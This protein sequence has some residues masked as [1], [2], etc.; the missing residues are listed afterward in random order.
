MPWTSKT[1]ND[2]EIRREKVR[3]LLQSENRPILINQ[4]AAPRH[5]TLVAAENLAV[6]SHLPGSG[7]AVKPGEQR[8]RMI[9]TLRQNDVPE[10]NTYLD[11][12]DTAMVVALAPI[13]VGAKKGDRFDVMVRLANQSEATDLAEGWLRQTQLVEMGN[14]GGRLRESFDLAVAEGSIVT[15]EQYSGSSDPGAKLQAKVVGGAVF[16]KDR[17]LGLGL[18]QEYAEAITMAAVVPVINKRFTYFDGSKQR[19]VAT[20]QSEDFIDLK[21]PPIYRLD[22]YHY[23]QVVMGLGFNE[24]SDGKRDR[25]EQL[26]RQI[27]LPGKVRE[28]CWQ[29][30]AEGSGAAEVLKN[31]LT[32]PDPEV[33][34]YCAHSLAYLSD[35]SAINTL[36][37]LAVS[38]S[39]FRQMCLNGL[40]ILEN[41]QAEEQL[42][43]LLHVAE[44]E[45]RYGAVRALR[46]RNEREPLVAGSELGIG[47]LLEIPSSGPALVA[48]SLDRQ[49]EIVF[50]GPVPQLNFSSTHNVSPNLLLRRSG[51]NGIIVTRLRPDQ[52]DISVRCSD[53]LPS[54]LRAMVQVRSGYGD[55][56]SLVRQCQEH[57]L[58]DVPVAMNPVPSSGRTYDRQ[59]QSSPEVSAVDELEMA[60]QGEATKGWYN[61]WSWWN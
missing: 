29:L 48:V 56:V 54:V 57:R 10:P 58:M 55:W 33:R 8:D 4:L 14:L 7:G 43:S 51:Q 31:G 39:A 61:P 44:P 35:P 28:A 46:D 15:N 1:S 21:I 3:K 23:V 60:S 53:D 12:K 17:D 34:F 47:S 41:H 9:E 13:G 16:K 42:K 50:F 18:M 11:G 59:T 37:E 45:V 19:G 36:A 25:L 32:D 30:E 2:I 52:E 20:P 38:Q 5:L 49:P 6:V 40:A 26:K 24:T 27:H 22:P